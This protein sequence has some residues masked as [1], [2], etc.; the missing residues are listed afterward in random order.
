[1]EKSRKYTLI[2]DPHAQAKKFINNMGK[3][4]LEGMVVLNLNDSNWLKILEEAIKLG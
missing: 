2:I 4:H 1:M 3:D